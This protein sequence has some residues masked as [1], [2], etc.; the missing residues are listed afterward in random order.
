MSFAQNGPV[1]RSWPVEW[2]QHKLLWIV[3]QATCRSRHNLKGLA[4]T[5]PSSVKGSDEIRDRTGF[6]P[7]VLKRFGGEATPASEEEVDGVGSVG[8]LDD[9]D[10]GRLQ[11]HHL[12][13]FWRLFD[14]YVKESFHVSKTDSFSFLSRPAIEPASP[15]PAGQEGIPCL[16]EGHQSEGVGRGDVQRSGRLSWKVF[17]F[18]QA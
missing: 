5:D 1:L 12:F 8:G 4:A 7:R 13:S 16:Q 18:R 9:S 17:V 3:A 11:L 15:S 14:G 2:T 10:D 6:V